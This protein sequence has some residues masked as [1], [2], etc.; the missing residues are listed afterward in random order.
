MLGSNTHTLIWALSRTAGMLYPPPRM[1]PPPPHIIWALPRTA[2]MLGRGRAGWSPRR[3]DGTC[4]L[5]FRF[6]VFVFVLSLPV[7]FLTYLRTSSAS[8]PLDPWL[9]LLLLPLPT[10]APSPSFPLF[11][12]SFFVVPPRCP[13][14]FV[15]FN[16]FRSS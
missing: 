16:A 12:T 1:Y 11:L 9:L 4:F 10:F 3:A 5:S 6:L 2:G 15:F 7:F 8:C 13:F 14:P